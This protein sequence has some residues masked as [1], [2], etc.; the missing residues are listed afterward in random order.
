MLSLTKLRKY[1]YNRER[2][3]TYINNYKTNYAY[4]RD[5]GFTANYVTLSLK[6][7]ESQYTFSMYSDDSC[8]Y[9]V[10]YKLNRIL[11]IEKIDDHTITMIFDKN[12]YKNINFMDYVNTKFDKMENSY[13]LNYTY[14]YKTILPSFTQNYSK[15]YKKYYKK[16]F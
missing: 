9:S 7:N 14:T 15:Y 3:Y 16:H 8:T 13:S 1:I 11:Y 5:F 6:I 10:F 12:Y 4:H 2:G